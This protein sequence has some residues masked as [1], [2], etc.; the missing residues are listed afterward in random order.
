MPFDEKL[1]DRIRNIVRNKGDFTEKKMFGGL[2]F[3]LSDKMCF[4]VLGN[5]LVA[6]LGPEQSETAIKKPHVSPMNFTGRALKGYVYVNF[7]G[8]KNDAALKAWIQQAILFTSS[9]V[10]KSGR[11]SKRKTISQIES[12]ETA[13]STPLSNLINFGPAT[14]PEFRAM[15]LKTYGQLE[16]LGWEAVCRKW[17][18]NFPERLNVNAFIGVIATLEG[19]SWT[20]ISPSDRAKARNLVQRLKQEYGIPIGRISKPRHKG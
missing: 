12:H 6:R 1:A 11:R 17:V 9:L 10:G 3:M 16:D 8:L 13:R 19:I 18:E 14:L 7:P 5:Q 2:A 15:G 20:K 4:G